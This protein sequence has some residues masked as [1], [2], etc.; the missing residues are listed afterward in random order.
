VIMTPT[1]LHSVLDSSDSGF[2]SGEKSEDGIAQVR[3][4]NVETD[5]RWNWESIRRI[6]KD[7]VRDRFFLEE[8][9]VLFNATNSPSLVGKTAYFAGIHEPIVF[10]NHFLRLRSQREKLD[11]RYLARWLNLLWQ[12]RL[13]ETRCKQWVNQAS[14]GKEDL[15]ALEIPLPPLA[16]Q[17]RIASILDAAD[18]LRTKR[19]EALAQLDTLLQST[20]LDMFGDPVTN[21]KGWDK[22]PLDEVG[23]FT[24]GGTPSKARDDFWIGANPWVSP[25]DMKVA[26]LRDAQDHVSDGAFRE[27]TLKLLQPGHLLIV[28]RGMILVHSFPAAI[29]LVPVA[30][31]QDMKA[32]RPSTKFDVHFLLECFR[33]LKRE[34]LSNVSTAAHGTKRFDLK[35]MREVG[36]IV[37][38][39]DLQHRFVS[40]MKIVER[41]KASMQAHLAELDTLFAS[42]QSRAFRGEL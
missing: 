15:L 26:Y 29:N 6:P 28:V 37:P 14:Y 22:R 5:G 2:A 13:F 17:K 42:L 39:L 25:K 19:R 34:I 8:G 4:N 31:N 35:G 38:P 27:T 33:R 7:S 3:M 21:P 23:E 10:S 24:S 41:Q 18:A 30:I 32:I 9:D 16:E 11:G 12:T 1:P 40:V 20:F 36:V